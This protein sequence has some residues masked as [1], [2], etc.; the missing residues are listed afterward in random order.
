VRWKKV[1]L[2]GVGLLGGSLGLALKQRRLAE[3]VVG[4]V[5]RPAS[6]K[7]CEK[8][9]AVN[10]AT[11]NLHEAVKG[12][13]LIVLCTPLAQMKALLKE[14]LPVSKP[15]ALVTDVGSVKGSVVTD[16]ERLLAGSTI[17]FVGSH[18][19]AGGEKM[20]VGAARADLFVNAVCV[21]TPTRRSKQSAVRAVEELW[22]SVG[23]RV[24]ELDPAAHDDLVSRSSHLPH[25]VAAAI[26]S[27]VLDSRRP[28]AQGLVCANGFRDVTRIASGSPEM[29]RDIGLA[30]SKHLGKALRSFIRDL[31]KLQGVIEKRDGVK[32]EKFFHNAKQL[33]DQ[34]H[35]AGASQAT[36]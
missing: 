6:V 13:D 32:L 25:L 28:A 8:A 35:S 21:V 7:D 16:F 36:E 5:R 11:L 18:P 29:W 10:Q 24:L 30:N 33:R 14:I 31:Q 4:F 23:G 17:Q 9:G 15:N 22:K 1:A 2:V 27:A 3:S 34:W 26:A 19:M 20:G 12:A